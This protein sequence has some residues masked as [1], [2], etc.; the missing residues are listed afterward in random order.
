MLIKGFLTAAGIMAAVPAIAVSQDH[1]LMGK[2]ARDD[3]KAHV[4][5]ER[6]GTDWCAINTWIKPGTKDEKVGDKLIMTLS[7]SE[8][9]SY[10]G[11]AHDPQR[12]LTFKIRVTAQPEALTTRGC[13]LGGVV[14]K[15]ARWTRL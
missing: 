2:W 11:S 7:D 8:G 4:K 3:G 1:P 15:T 6:C 5:I 12:K 13:V 14:C 10:D 9:D